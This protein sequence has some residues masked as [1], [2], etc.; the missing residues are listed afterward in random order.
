MS[1]L[2]AEAPFLIKLLEHDFHSMYLISLLQALLQRL[3]S[4]IKAYPF[5]SGLAA[6]ATV[7]I[8]LL[9]HGIPLYVSYISIAGIVTT[10]DQRDYGLPLHVGAGGG[11]PSLTAGNCMI[12]RDF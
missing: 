3:T 9:E 10:T 2:V 5:M 11:G 12:D 1:D 7:S 6:S 8:E 4:E